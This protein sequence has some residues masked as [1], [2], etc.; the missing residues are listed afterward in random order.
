M[1]YTE[2]YIPFEIPRRGGRRLL[3]HARGG[4]VVGVRGGFLGLL[5]FFRRRLCQIIVVLVSLTER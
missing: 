4:V 2:R 1:R 5:F 3:V